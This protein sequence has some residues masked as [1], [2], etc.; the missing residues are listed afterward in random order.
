VKNRAG[1]RGSCGAQPVMPIPR[2]WAGRQ[3]RSPRSRTPLA[4]R[5]EGAAPAWVLFSIVHFLCG[6]GDAEEPGCACGPGR[7]LAKGA[8]DVAASLAEGK[9]AAC[10]SSRPGEIAGPPWGRDAGPLAALGGSKNP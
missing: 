6:A 7:L 8:G 4:G 3:L 5:L 2:T 9:L 1:A 10:P